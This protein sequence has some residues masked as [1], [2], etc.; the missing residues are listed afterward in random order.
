METHAAQKMGR[1]LPAAGLGS[2]FARA[3]RSDLQ[4]TGLAGAVIAVVIVGA[5]ASPQFLTLDNMLNVARQ[6]S[7]VALL[8][9]AVTISLIAGIVDFSIGAVL[10][11]TSVLIGITTHQAPVVTLALLLAVV[12]GVGLVKALLVAFL[13]LESLITTL[14]IALVLEGVA[15]AVSDQQLVPVTHDGW[16][17]LGSAELAGIPASLLTVAIVAGG[18]YVALRWTVYGRYLYATGGNR[19]AAEI[20]GVPTR[21]VML[22]ALLATTAIAALAGILFVGRVAAGDPG[23]GTSFALD[24]VVVAVLGGASLFGGRGGV[25]GLILAAALIALMFN[26][27]TLLNLPTHWQMIVRGTILVGA[28]SLDVFRRR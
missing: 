24:A 3:M 1:P 21:R 11:L 10:A 19:L 8:G 4:L 27:F 7:I 16:R 9:L 23:V 22:G 2:A 17:W 25:V 12:L 28:I 18:A 15:F 6:G 26:L 14:G 5:I 20:A 13:G